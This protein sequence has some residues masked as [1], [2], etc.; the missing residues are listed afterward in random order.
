M[1]RI[2][3]TIGALLL[4]I[5]VINA[6]I[7]E[8]YVKAVETLETGVSFIYR[9]VD[10]P[11]LDIT[12]HEWSADSITWQKDRDPG[13]CYIRFSNDVKTTWAGYNVCTGAGGGGTGNIDTIFWTVDGVTDTVVDGSVS[14]YI[15]EPD[16]V[17]GSS[18]NF[19][20]TETHTHELYISINDNEDVDTTGVTN[21][22]VI[23][24]NSVTGDWEPADDL[25]AGGASGYLTVG[26]ID[27]SPSVINV[28]E[29]LITNGTVTDNGAG[30]V[31][32]DLLQEPASGEQNFYRTD[33]IRVAAGDTFIT[34][35]S[36]LP[37]ANYII[38]NAY[39]MYDDGTKQSLVSDSS[40]VDGFRVLSILED[41]ATVSYLAMLPVDSLSLATA[42]VGKILASSSDPTLGYLNQKVDDT[43][44]TVTTQELHVVLAPDADSL[45]GIH[46]SEYLTWTDTTATIATAFDIS[47]FVTGVASSTD[48]A[49]TRWHGT[50][51]DSIQNSTIITDD[52]GNISA[53]NSL[54]LTAITAP[55]HA[56][57]TL[58]YDTDDDELAFYDS[59]SSTK[60]NIGSEMRT[61]VRNNSG[62]PIADFTPVYQ[63]GAVG[64][65]ATIDLAKAD[66]ESTS[67][68]YAVTTSLI[69]NNTNAS[70]TTRGTINGVDTDGSPYGETWVAGDEIFLSATTAGDLTNVAPTGNNMSVS[71]G[72]VLTAANN[73]SFEV[74]IDGANVVGIA[75][76]TDN[77][78]VRW[79]G[80]SGKRIKESTGIDASEISIPTGS[81]SPTVDDI[82]AYLDNTGSSGFFLGG[83]LSDGG[84]GTLDV[85]AGSGFIRTTNDANAELQSFKWSASAGIA[86]TD[87]TTQYVYVDDAGTISLSTDEFLETPD[88]IQIGVVTKESGAVE[89]VFSLGVRLEESV[90]QAGRFIRRVHGI[91]RD[92]RKGG[93]IFGQSG[94]VNRDVS[95][96]AGMLWWGRTE[97]T[98][99]AFNTSSATDTFQTYSASGQEDIAASQWPNEQYD[100]SGTLTTMDNNRWANLFFFIEPDDHIVMIYGRDQFLSEALADA[101]D[102][103][104]SS[105]PT[106]VSETSILAARY[107]FQESSNTATIS[108]AFEQLFANASV[109]DHANLAT[110]AWTSAGHTGTVSTFAGF[111]GS[112]LAT[113]YTESNYIQFSDTTATIATRYDIDTTN[114]A[115]ALNTLKETNVTTD[116][117]FT[118]ST[119]TVNSSDGTD[120]TI[121]NFGTANTDYGFVVGSNSA[122]NTNFLRADGSW[123]AP[124]GGGDVSFSDTVSIIATKYDID[125][126]NVAV[127]LNT[128]KETNVSTDLAYTAT[129][130][131]VTSSDGTDATIGLFPTDSEL[132]GLVIG[133]NSVG[134]TYFLDGS[135]AWSIPAGS[136]SQDLGFTVGTGEI[137]ISGGN[138]VTVGS[139]GTVNT[140][141]GF[142][143]GSN[144]LGATYY[145]DGSGAWSVPATDH[146]AVTLNASATTGGMTISTQEISNRAATNAQTGYMTAALVTNI[147]T[148]NGKVTNSDQDLSYNSG[149]HA[150][151]I[152]DGTNAVIPLSLADGATEGLASFAAADFTATSGNIVIDYTNGQKA[153]NAQP[154]FAT[155]AHIT[156][157]EA[158]TSGLAAVD[159]QDV[160]DN[161]PST[162]NSVMIGSASAPKSKLNIEGNSNDARQLIINS[163][164]SPNK[165]LYIGW[166]EDGDYAAIQAFE[167]ASGVKN[168][169]LQQGGGNIG[170]G[171]DTPLSE[172]AI[173]GGLHVGGASDAGDNNLLVDGTITATGDVE[174][175]EDLIDINDSPGTAGQIL[176]SLGTGSGTDWIDAGGGSASFDVDIAQGSHGLGVDD[177]IYHNGTIYVKALADDPATSGVVGVVTAVADAGNFTYTYGGIITGTYTNG[178]AYFLSNTVAGAIITEPSYNTGDV[179]QYIGMG[180]ETDLLLEIDIGDEITAVGGGGTVTDVSVVTANGF[181][182]TVAT[183]TT[184]PAITLTTSITGVLKGNGT[185]ISA[186]ASGT[187]YVIPSGSV[188]TLTTPRA[189][190]GNDFDGSAALTQIIAS[191]YGGTGN[192]FTKFAGATTAEKT[193]TLPDA[194]ATLLYSGGDAGTPSALVGTNISG[195]ASGLTAGTVTGFTPA[196]GSL[197]LAGADALTL[198][199]TGTTNSTLPLGTKTL[200]ATDVT[201]LSSLAT[202]G[203]VTGGTIS[204]LTVILNTTPVSTNAYITYNDTEK[205]PYIGNGTAAVPVNNQTTQTLTE[206]A[207]AVAQNWLSGAN[208]TVTIDEATTLTLSNVPDGE[209]GTVAITQGDAGDDNITFAHAGLTVKY[210][211]GD[212]DLTDTNA[213]T[214][215]VSYK[216]LGAF[217]YVTIG[218]NY[219]E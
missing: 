201:S 199:T 186:A 145:I 139:F 193:Y 104:S 216:R 54:G 41:S 175:N 198:T 83:A 47:E 181:A 85:A 137:T 58:F 210:R 115:V 219:I 80:A 206:T 177:A 107:T 39:A 75:S 213:I 81:G 9:G 65:R 136:D 33:T 52:S 16:T 55:A 19:Q 32:I 211:D 91:T 207:G 188:A 138:N 144:S 10:I 26:E 113:E 100:N 76:S 140:N 78:I 214:D 141:Y 157:I 187:D 84:A 123:A 168:L 15:T 151:D 189:I 156:A 191:T 21:G 101:E 209:S 166:D 70:A 142:V 204:G 111:D 205:R 79:D 99:T 97:Y 183:S 62:S 23:K 124:A 126:T 208:A 200:V 2:L 185:A 179:R 88:K 22:Q 86:V 202:V 60:L 127:A 53:V 169:I 134:A 131:V 182:G 57:G 74:K 176:S 1:R 13:D 154:G 165:E 7:Q 184:T 24:W 110:L 112:G 64:N 197:T 116:I 160:T 173:D 93:L 69:G 143:V 11:V 174:L 63:T 149:T 17:S 170:I 125:T 103:P 178:T 94:D 147:E 38:A 108:S 106:K 28:I 71:I 196:S 122:D 128:L 50:S 212:Q 98:I 92:K 195:T 95:M 102:V 167:Q 119:G 18:T 180:V 192:G 96:T 171:F 51:G 40:A 120:A 117:T 31:T 163:A 150:V 159:L 37:A 68:V 14:M 90:G 5:G 82:Q 153:T 12:Y 130:G 42:G 29:I 48:N 215:L 114:V 77:T 194:N 67:M 133:S 72:H 146:V 3:S 218:L 25:L 27:G 35:S 66:V 135:G 36:A 45:G 4:F 6:Q 164:T 203:T 87:N 172:L 132:Y 109:T 89:H 8:R 105:L 46:S 49:L 61:K 20:D 30:S 152:T 43:T 158:N 148:N 118:A 44:I 34:F 162:T 56:A 121:G 161:D 129:T 155:A 190:Y 217:L 59:D 73:G